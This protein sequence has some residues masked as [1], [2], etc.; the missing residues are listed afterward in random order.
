MS[1]QDILLAIHNR[2]SLIMPNL[3]SHSNFHLYSILQ[4]FIFFKSLQ[5]SVDDTLFEN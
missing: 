2:A 4:N 3:D 5:L 1:E